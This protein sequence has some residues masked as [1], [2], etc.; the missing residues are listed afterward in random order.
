MTKK[1]EKLEAK[2][3]KSTLIE[4]FAMWKQTSKEG[5]SYFTGKDSGVDLRGFYNTKKKNPK[6]PDVRIYKVDDEGKLDKEVFLSL[7]CNAT[8]KGKKYLTGKL[9]GERVVAFINEK[10]TKENKQPY[11]TVYL[12]DEPVKQEEMK[13]VKEVEKKPAKEKQVADNEPF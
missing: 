3:Q 13:E 4:K 5:K 11:F 6:E 9:A 10:A 7:W 8:E 2:T 12:S 1:N